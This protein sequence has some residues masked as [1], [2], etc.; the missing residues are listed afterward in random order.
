MAKKK[1]AK[2]TDDRFNDDGTMK[3]PERPVRTRDTEDNKAVLIDN[4][5]R[6]ANTAMLR[7][8]KLERRIDR[9]VD[10][11]SKSRNLKGL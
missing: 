8:A 6:E 1:T 4:L 5:L 2:K 11:I 3:M 7:I 9:I 10:A